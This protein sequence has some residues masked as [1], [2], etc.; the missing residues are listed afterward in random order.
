MRILSWSAIGAS[1]LAIGCATADSQSTEVIAATDNRIPAGVLREG[2]LTLRLEAREGQWFPDG[3]DGPA[4]VMQ[5]FAEMG[6]VAQNPGPLIR[7]PAGTMIRL[8]IH[9]ALRDSVLIL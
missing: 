7:V 1:L 6:K 9:S 3:A 4:L 2:V 5:T 8:S